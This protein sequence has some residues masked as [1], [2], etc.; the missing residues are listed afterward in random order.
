[1]NVGDVL[2]TDNPQAPSHTMVVVSK[3]SV[4]TRKFV[5]IRGFNN[6]GTLG[7]GIRDAYDASDHDIDRDKYWN[8]ANFGNAGVPLHRIPYANYSAAAVAVRNNCNNNGGPW[9][10]VGP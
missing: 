10:Y 4:M 3:T 5:S 1:M 8:D 9:V 7:T 6:F 2:V